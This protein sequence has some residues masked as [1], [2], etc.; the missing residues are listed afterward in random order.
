M[1]EY[2]PISFVPTVG[3]RD[4]LMAVAMGIAAQVVGVIIY[5]QRAMPII[6]PNA[7]TGFYFGR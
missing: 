6:N 7:C 3:V 1:L 2:Y 4:G 5:T